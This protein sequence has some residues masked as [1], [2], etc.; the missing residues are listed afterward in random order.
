LPDRNHTPRA[1]AQ[2]L[3]GAGTFPGHCPYF[4]RRNIQIAAVVP[5]TVNQEIVSG[6]DLFVRYQ[7]RELIISGRVASLVCRIVSGNIICK[8]GSLVMVSSL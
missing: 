5:G 3:A 7:E 6:T 2:A 1:R 4:F 8:E